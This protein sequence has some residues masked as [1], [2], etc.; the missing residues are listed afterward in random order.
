M[1]LNHKKFQ[2]FSAIHCDLDAKNTHFQPAETQK[3]KIS[4]CVRI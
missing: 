4:Q 3:K 1:T 2:H